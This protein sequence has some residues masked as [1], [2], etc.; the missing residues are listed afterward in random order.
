MLIRRGPPLGVQ[1]VFILAT[2][3]AF[4]YGY[5]LYNKV[6]AQLEDLEKSRGSLIIEKEDFL[7]DLRGVFLLYSLKLFTIIQLKRVFQK[8][9]SYL[10]DTKNS[11]KINKFIILLV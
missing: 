2:I 10:V 11:F 4:F 5:I 7:R 6:L 8:K 1:I 9:N 3:L